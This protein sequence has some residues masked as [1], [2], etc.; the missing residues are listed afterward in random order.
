MTSLVE[1]VQLTVTA[2]PK[3]GSEKV[4][5]LSTLTISIMNDAPLAVS[6]HLFDKPLQFEIWNPSQRYK[7]Q[8]GCTVI[9]QHFPKNF[10]ITS[11]QK[12]CQ[13]MDCGW[14]FHKT[15]ILKLFGKWK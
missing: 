13:M 4:T 15:T 5:T 8:V 6:I 1:Q 3:E 9:F 7:F 14:R 12:Y 11:R 10:L 2:L